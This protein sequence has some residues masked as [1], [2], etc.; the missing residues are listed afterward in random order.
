MPARISL[1]GNMA[2]PSSIPQKALNSVCV[3]GMELTDIINVLPDDSDIVVLY[4]ILRY[5]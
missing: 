5:L 2:R 1:T 3:Y 4:R